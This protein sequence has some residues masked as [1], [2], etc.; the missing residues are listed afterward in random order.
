MKKALVHEW[1]TSLAGSEMCL[2]SFTNIWNDFTVFGL[3]NY[4][5]KEELAYLGIS[6]VNTSPIQQLP[7]AEK[8]FRNYLPLFPYAV[9]QHDLADY[10][11]ILSSSHATAKG[12]ITGPNQLHICYC[13]TPMRYAWDLY[14]EYMRNWGL[15]KGL[16]ALMV[17]AALHYIRQWDVT[18]STRVDAFIA[19]SKFT[20]GRIKKF[21]NREAKVIYPPVE[22][23]DFIP[24][25]STGNYFVTASRLV[26]Y[27]K[28]DII[29]QAFSAMPDKRLVIIG[30]GPELNFI[31]EKSSGN[32]EFAGYLSREQMAKTIAG[33]RAFVFAALEDFGIVAVEA[34]ATGTPVI[35]LNR[36]GT[37]ESVINGVTGTHFREQTPHSIRSAVEEFTR[38]EASF[39]RSVIREHALGFSRERFEQEIK[40]FCEA[41]ME[42]FF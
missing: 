33:A 40:E 32:I 17:K 13:H 26:P 11:F 38:N 41:E 23:A 3:V 15:N 37:A 2:K 39:N 14:H 8:H 31:K 28:I 10:D 30:E 36:G 21:Y 42:K 29:A 6:K 25:S 5:S 16:K 22:T 12:G 1:F 9:E 20:A 4:L 35:A 34:M 7:F 24:V 19:N 18:S 27:K